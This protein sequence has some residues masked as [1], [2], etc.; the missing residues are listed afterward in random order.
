[1]KCVANGSAAE[2]SKLVGAGNAV[3]MTAQISAC[4]AYDVAFYHDAE[5]CILV[6]FLS[7]GFEC[8][9]AHIA[10]K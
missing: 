8:V 9:E 3:L 4:N 1:M 2:C 7:Y 10:F 6:H 5:Q